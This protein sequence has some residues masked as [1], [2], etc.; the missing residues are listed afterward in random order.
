[1]KEKKESQGCCEPECGPGTCGSESE[2][3]GKLRVV[4]IK[5]GSNKAEESEVAAANQSAPQKPS[6]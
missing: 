5:P 4:T 6:G 1:M 3:K 2:P